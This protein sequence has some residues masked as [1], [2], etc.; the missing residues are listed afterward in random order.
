M[1]WW[2]WITVGALL[3]V[4]ELTIVDFEFYL[5]FLGA[6][7]FLVGLVDVL[8]IEMPFWMQWIVFAALAIASLVF[9]RQR[10]YKW[11][12]P[13]PDAAVR[14]GVEGAR[15]VAIDSIE[16]G[17]T[18]RVRLRGADWS[19]RNVGAEP[20][21]GGASCLVERADGLILELHLDNRQGGV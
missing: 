5:V 4:A 14:E 10:A 18:G 15:A 11:I 21:P 20:I 9:F 3:L 17:Q 12:R 7:A 1:P 19:G 6:A 8:G 13:P 16:V 2:G